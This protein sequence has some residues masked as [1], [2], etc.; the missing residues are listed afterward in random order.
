MAPTIMKC[1]LPNVHE[2]FVCIG[3]SFSG[4]YS[5][6]QL[7]QNNILLSTIK[8]SRFS[9]LFCK[10]Q[11]FQGL[12]FGPIKLANSTEFMTSVHRTTSQLNYIRISVCLNILLHSGG[13]VVGTPPPDPA[14]KMAPLDQLLMSV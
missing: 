13:V 12:E 4:C 9:R 2:L 14:Q 8:F 3:F 5:S 11:G 10:I 6:K 7:S 1:R